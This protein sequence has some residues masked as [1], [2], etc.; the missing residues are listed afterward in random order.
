M[1]NLRIII[2]FIKD[3]LIGKIKKILVKILHKIKIILL[4]LDNWKKT[5]NLIIDEECKFQP[6]IHDNIFRYENRKSEDIIINP[7]A[8]NYFLSKKNLKKKNDEEKKNLF[9]QNQEQGQIT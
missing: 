8:M 6:E 7:E 4:D 1:I 3:H 9:Y 2:I 5:M